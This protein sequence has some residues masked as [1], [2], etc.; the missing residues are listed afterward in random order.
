MT[1]IG[2]CA[3]PGAGIRRGGEQGKAAGGARASA[4]TFPTH[5]RMSERNGR[6]PWSEFGRAPADC[7][8][9]RSR[10]V[11]ATTA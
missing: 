10:P 7:A 9:Q 5:G 6:R 2:G 1:A 4:P 8:A 11:G 3:P